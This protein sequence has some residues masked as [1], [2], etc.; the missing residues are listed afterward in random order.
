[1]TLAKI[2]T[3]P[4]TGK[5]SKYARELLWGVYRQ[6]RSWQKVADRLGLKNRGHAWE[7]AMGKRHDTPEMQAACKNAKARERRARL[8]YRVERVDRNVDR[9]LVRQARVQVAALASTL[10]AI[11]SEDLHDQPSAD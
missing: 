1:M 8:G 5:S 4:K 7:M 3:P 2:P 9:E 11:E 10:K 6:E